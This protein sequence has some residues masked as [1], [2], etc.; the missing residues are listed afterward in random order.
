LSVINH[1]QTPAIALDILNQ[2]HS[3][4][5]RRFREVC[6]AYLN[7]ISFSSWETSR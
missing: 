5:T 7:F 2:S 3:K 4:P 1:R 6:L